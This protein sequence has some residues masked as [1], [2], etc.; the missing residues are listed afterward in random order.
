MPQMKI[1]KLRVTDD[2]G[3]EHEWEGVAGSLI[4]YTTYTKDDKDQK[5]YFRAVDAHLQLEN[6]A[7]PKG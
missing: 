3:V 5:T 2:K 4:E 1:V 7:P 6:V